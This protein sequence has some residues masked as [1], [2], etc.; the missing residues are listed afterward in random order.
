MHQR[1]HYCDVTR[2][3]YSD[4]TEC[5]TIATHD[6]YNAVAADGIASLIYQWRVFWL[7]FVDMLK[8]IS[9]NNVT[10][11]DLKRYIIQITMLERPKISSSKQPKSPGILPSALTSKSLGVKI[12]NG[13]VT[14]KQNFKWLGLQDRRL[15]TGPGFIT[16]H[17]LDTVP[18]SIFVFWRCIGHFIAYFTVGFSVFHWFGQNENQILRNISVF[19]RVSLEPL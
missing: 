17:G 5:S 13:Q 7:P 19:H 3:H 15:K 1:Q 16:G 4:V 14:C 6:A 8:N 18:V 12:E 2:H 9:Y 11:I 10:Y